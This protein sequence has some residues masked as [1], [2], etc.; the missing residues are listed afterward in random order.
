MKL[1]LHGDTTCYNEGSSSKSYKTMFILLRKKSLS[2]THFLILKYIEKWKIFSY[3]LDKK[4][5]NINKIYLKIIPN[6]F[7]NISYL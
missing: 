5:K 1:N 2:L 3:F 4:Y 7:Y 6:L